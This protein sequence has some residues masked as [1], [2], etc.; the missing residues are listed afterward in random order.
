MPDLGSA[1][2]MF[3]DADTPA[4]PP[5]RP[6]AAPA[7]VPARGHGASVRLIMLGS[8]GQPMGE[9]MLAGE[10]MEVGRSSGPPWDDDAYLDPR[11]AT[12]LPHAS[13]L[14]VGHEAV[15]VVDAMRA[16]ITEQI[17]DRVAS[18]SGNTRNRAH[19]IAL[20]QSTNDSSLTVRRERVHG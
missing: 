15:M 16:E 1:R 7:A 3:V 17:G 4:P 14:Q 9:R 12:L 13:G 11:H 6:A 20:D 2:T 19:R 5:A 10:V 8:D 18:N